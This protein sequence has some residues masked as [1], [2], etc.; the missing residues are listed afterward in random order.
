MNQSQQKAFQQAT[1]CE[2]YFDDLVRQ[3]Y[4]TDA[5]PYQVI[6]DAVAFPRTAKQAAEAIKVA[7]D[8][9]I[10]VVPRGAGT[11]LTGGAL[12]DGLVVDFARH[13]G[14]ITDFNAEERTVRVGAG[15][16]L[17]Q[18]N[19]W[20]QPHGLW[21]GPDVA[22]SSRATLGGMIGNNSS[23]AHVP[24]YGT[25]V[26]H[27]LELEVVLADGTVA[28][29]GRNSD[30]LTDQRF[31]M[32]KLVDQY[33][34]QINERMPEG[35]I[36][37]RWPGYGFDHY[38]RNKGD[39]A[40]IITGS[41]GTL[42]GVMSAKLNLV[43]VPPKKRIG[44]I[45]FNSV[46]E[47]MQATVELLD[48]E[49]AAIEHVDRL[50]FDQTKGQRTF[51]RARAFMELD[52]K[53]CESFLIV[54]FFDD[55][56][57]G[58][59]QELSQRNI[60]QR[61]LIPSNDQEQLLVWQVRKSGLS[62]L[63][64]C[65]GPAKPIAGLEDVAV[66]P[67]K[68]ADYVNGLWEIFDS[69]GIQT[70][71]YGHAASGLLH[72]R[73]KLD[74]HT[75]EDIRKFREV[76]EEVS[77]LCAQFKGSIAGEHGVGISRTEFLPEHLGDDLMRASW[78]VKKMFDP[79]NVMNPGKILPG[80]NYKIDTNL[81][82][83][84]GYRIE[85]PFEPLNHFV[86]RDDDFVSNLEQCNGC[87]DCR[88]EP[89]TM[90]P[91]FVAMKEEIMSTRGRANTIR[92]ALDGRLGDG[93]PLTLEDLDKALDYCLSCKA[94]KTECP[95]NVDLTLLKADLKHA[96]HQKEGTP[97]VDR[98]IANSDLLGR[99]GT[100]FNPIS[101]WA[102]KL[103]MTGWV[104]SKMFGF[105]TERPMPPYAT[106]RFD[107]W[108]AKHKANGANN[109]QQASRG[110]VILWDD[111]W[112]RYNEPNIGHAA[113]KVLEAAGFE[114]VLPEG[115]KCC[116]RPAASRGVLDMVE[117]L[118]K[119]NVKLFNEQGGDEPILFLEP[120]CYS[121]FVDEYRQM[122]IEGAEQV[123]R[124]CV[125]F[126]QFVYELLRREPEALKFKQ[127]GQARV[128]IHGHC[129]SKA[130]TD[131]NLMPELAERVPNAEANFLE[132]G[133]CGMAGAFGMMADK[134]E[135]SKMVAQ[136]LVDKINALEAGTDM[137]ASGTSCRHQITHLTKAEPLHMA[138][139]LAKNLE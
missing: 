28:T 90:C 132:T 10:S 49:P 88:K 131:A 138:E 14:Q 84:E 105:T 103:P 135:V 65:K 4:A 117:K 17:D 5:S 55:E 137:V 120:S 63:T 53:P 104:M 36:N 139:F 107:K 122:K 45:F 54:E 129:H 39:L 20:L 6:P 102:L 133:C 15:V 46:A 9:G 106:Q 42:A 86:E 69:R 38:L 21:F 47:A 108:F 115:R 110:K 60:G 12:G 78:E 75:G 126:E 125:L 3:L 116:G 91:T 11:G 64:A 123:A 25:T 118:G 33:A 77:A 22:T 96:R 57:D 50:L 29:I 16:V 98:V 83:G 114:V 127:N 87:G 100:M 109:G 93:D 70:S 2:V 30:T 71:Y 58:K 44:L 43:P 80:K 111:T 61:T 76:A 68:V 82:W 121:M 130:L 19:N 26:D 59:L 99:L 124:R 134:Y 51:A 41:E 1:D 136:P 81:R 52:E 8:N 89:P 23:G 18:L 95:S 74:L 34:D 73:P 13:N 7:A 40:K 97:L 113:V 35:F 92:A 48:L 24:K 112:V 62:L 119:H 72:V 31:A 67:H 56:A 94:C 27:V 128:A 32:D 66:P 101:N 37:K 79:R 85:L